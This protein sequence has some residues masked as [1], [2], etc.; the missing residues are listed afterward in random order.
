MQDEP[1]GLTVAVYDVAEPVVGAVQDGVTM[2]S[3]LATVTPSGA[4]GGPPPTIQL[5]IELDA[6]TPRA[7]VTVRLTPVVVLSLSVQFR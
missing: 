6:D 7:S 2:A 1:P 3:P 5:N 4:D